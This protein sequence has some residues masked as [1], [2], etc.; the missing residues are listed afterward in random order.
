ME[1]SIEVIEYDEL[2][3]RLGHGRQHVLLGNG[4]SIA[5]DP[6]FRYERLYDAAV[7]AGL[8]ERAQAVFER[9]GTSNFERVMRLLEDAWWIA[10][11]YGLSD[12][13]E[14]EM[15]ADVNIVKETLV[16]AVADSHLAHT[17]LVAD[18]KKAAA[19]EFLDPY[20]NVFT[21]NYDLLTYWVTMSQEG[22]PTWQDGFRADPDDPDTP[23]VVFSERIGG[24]RGLFYL[25][26]ALHLHVVKG[27][28]RKHCW[29]RTGVPLTQLIQEGLAAGQYP[30]FVAEGQPEAKLEQIQRTGYL[31]Y[32]LDKLSRVASPLV[33]FGHSLGA[34]DRHI[35]DAI[36]D[37]VDLGV[38]AVGLHGD[39]EGAANQQIRASLAGVQARREKRNATL[40][41]PRPLEVIFFDSDSANVW[42]AD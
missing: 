16:D 42:G 4:F 3:E 2:R 38:L 37:N 35:G 22:G 18:E 30:L 5:C 23:Y 11:L 1:T 27:E 41:R 39:P 19:L 8:S 25:H 20:Y 10:E 21:T 28:L 24:S 15:L 32:A 14:S 29:S 17:G 26:G 13:S 7:E 34:S 9:L 36:A 33:V 40:R 12:G 6:I 31:W